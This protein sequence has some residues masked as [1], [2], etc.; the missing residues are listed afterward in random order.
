MKEVIYHVCYK[1]RKTTVHMNSR[2]LIF[3]TG[4]E[5]EQFLPHVLCVEGEM[6]ILALKTTGSIYNL[7]LVMNANNSYLTCHVL[8]EKCLSSLWKRQA[9]Y[10]CA[11]SGVKK[12]SREQF[13]VCGLLKVRWLVF[14]LSQ[15]F[16]RVIKVR[17]VN[18]LSWIFEVVS[19][20]GFN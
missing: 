9:A 19:I 3:T 15:N 8:R 14:P 18:F 7:Q 13:S 16:L 1:R 2:S 12:G 11:I 6:S 20:Q 5:C 4:Y 17:A 10:P